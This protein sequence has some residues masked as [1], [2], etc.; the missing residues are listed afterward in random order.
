MT[1]NWKLKISEKTFSVL[2][3]VKAEA[4]NFAVLVKWGHLETFHGDRQSGSSSGQYT[5]VYVI[6]V[7]VWAN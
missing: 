2:F 4:T 7:T 3:N 5:H 1:I 6:Y